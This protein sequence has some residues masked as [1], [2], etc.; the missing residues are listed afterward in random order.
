M[1]LQQQRGPLSATERRTYELGRRRYAEGDPEGALAAFRKFLATRPTYADVHYM[2][3][4]LFER[5]DELDAAAESWRE[6]L[7]LN[8]SYIEALLAL[9]SLHEREGDF[10]M[11]RQL[12]ERAGTVGQAASGRVDP[13]TRA[14]LANLE[15][16]LADAYRDAGEWRAAIDGYRRSLARCPHFHDVRFRLALAL[17][18]A[19]RPDAALSEFLRIRDANPAFLEARVQTGVTLYS[20][21]RTREAVSH[22]EAVL[23]SDAGHREARMYLRLVPRSAEFGASQRV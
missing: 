16:E 22:W 9:A 6:A 2:V 13:T 17:R 20:L 19:G 7:R 18:E 15:A 11:S 23:A 5:R 3:G 1:E 4:T 8:P 12:T 14:K 21:G 10:E